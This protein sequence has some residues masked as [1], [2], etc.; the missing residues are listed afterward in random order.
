MSALDIIEIP[1]YPGMY[2]R[3]ILVEAWQEAGSPPI[4]KPDGAGRLHG[5]QKRLYDGWVDREPGFFPADN[6]DDETQALGHVRF[7][8]LDID[9]TPARIEALEAAGLERPYEHEPWHW[10]LPNI[11]SYPIVRSIPIPPPPESEEDE[12]TATFINIEGKTGSHRGGC[13]AIMR[14]NNGKL[15]ARFVSPKPLSSAPTIPADEYPA[16]TKTMPIK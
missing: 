5:A 4:T 1:G 11:R 16:W 15:F 13:Y 8:A 7:A 10:A 3:R 9:P 14:D 12:M 2:A 6:P